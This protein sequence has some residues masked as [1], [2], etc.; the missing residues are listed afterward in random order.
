MN[1]LKQVTLIVMNMQVASILKVHTN[2]NARMVSLATGKQTAQV[3][4]P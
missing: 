2:V 4:G 1:A 3:L